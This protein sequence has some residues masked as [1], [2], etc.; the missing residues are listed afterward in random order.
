MSLQSS[1][2]RFTGLVEDLRRVLEFPE[3]AMPNAEPDD[4]L[5]VALDA[6]IDLS[7]VL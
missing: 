2:H 5:L 3:A 6:L 1:R 4:A 7:T